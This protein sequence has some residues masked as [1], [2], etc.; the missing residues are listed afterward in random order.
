MMSKM[1][2]GGE[3]LG[4]DVGAAIAKAAEM[5]QNPELLKQEI[6]DKLVS[7]VNNTPLGKLAQEQ[8]LDIGMLARIAEGDYSAIVE[9]AT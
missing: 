1:L 3:I 8:G 7:A 5:A 6:T 9:L 2:K 4:M